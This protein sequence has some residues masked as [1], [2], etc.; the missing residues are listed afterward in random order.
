M[1]TSSAHIGNVDDDVVV[2]LVELDVV[3]DVVDDVVELDVDVVVVELVVELDVVVDVVKL[4]V[5]LDVVVDVVDDVVELDVDVVVVEL[6]VELDVVVDVVELVVELDVDVVVELVVELEVDDDVDD[7]VDVVVVVIQSTR[8]SSTLISSK[9]T[10]WSP[11]GLFC[12]NLSV[13]QY[14]VAVNLTTYRP[15]LSCP[16]VSNTYTCTP[17]S[18][19]LTTA[20]VLPGRWAA[21]NVSCQ[22]RPGRNPHSF[23]SRYTS[24]L[25]LDVCST[26]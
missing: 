17:S 15:N 24:W 13:M 22:S 18:L 5:E 4:V 11:S 23:C 8:S 9:Y 12:S 6:V 3:V 16:N 7:D 21:I 14:D 26:P 10:A 19:M 25:W 20:P 1:S 2:E